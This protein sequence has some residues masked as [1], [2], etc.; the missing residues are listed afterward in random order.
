MTSPW[1]A[2]FNSR[3]DFPSTPADS[4]FVKLDMIL[5][6]SKKETMF[7]LKVEVTLDRGD[8]WGI[9]HDLRRYFG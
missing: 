9:S 5:L 8:Q 7:M 2:S 3:N 4:L 1:P 6:T